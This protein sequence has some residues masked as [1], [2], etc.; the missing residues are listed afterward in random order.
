M[1]S[2]M[3]VRLLGVCSHLE[4]SCDRDGRDGVGVCGGDTLVLVVEV[5]VERFVGEDF[6]GDSV[7]VASKSRGWF[8]VATIVEARSPAAELSCLLVVRLR[9]S[10]KPERRSKEWSIVETMSHDSPRS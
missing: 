9:K 6:A 4:A 3:R 7:A 8:L 5:R 2:Q 10:V 1:A